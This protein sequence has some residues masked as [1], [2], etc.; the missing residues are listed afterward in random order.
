MARLFHHGRDFAGRVLDRF[1]RVTRRRH[2]A[3]R[4]YLQEVGTVAQIVACGL[5]YGFDAVAD[6]AERAVPHLAGALRYRERAR[7]HVAVAAGLRQH[8]SRAHDARTGC[9]A[10]LDRKDQT[11]DIAT[12]VARRG[13]AALHRFA[14]EARHH[15]AEFDLAPFREF[16]EVERR[17]A[18]VHVRVDEARQHIG[19][20]RVDRDVGFAGVF[21]DG[22][23]DAVFGDQRLR[24]GEGE[25]VGIKAVRI[26]NDE[27]HQCLPGG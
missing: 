21:T 26:T 24:A 2:A 4:V 25:R 8:A 9:H 17:K 6:D 7:L 18:E 23:D 3:G 12:Q 10:V 22:G 16:V 11:F 1:Q 13:E 27:A 5:A 20:L 19:A 15:D 14:R